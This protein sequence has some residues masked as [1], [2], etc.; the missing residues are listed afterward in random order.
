MPPASVRAAEGPSPPARAPADTAA[1]AQAHFFVCNCARCSDE[2]LAGVPPLAAVRARGEAD[3]D[4]TE[5]AV[6]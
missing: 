1:A 2:L 5:A 3:A 4:V 6:D